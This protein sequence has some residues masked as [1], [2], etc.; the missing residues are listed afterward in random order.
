[1]DHDLKQW[2]Q[3]YKVAKAD[4]ALLERII[5]QA[6]NQPSEAAIAHSWWRANTALAAGLV[7][8]AVLGFAGGAMTT[9]DM[10]E[11]RY[12]QESTIDH[13]DMYQMILTPQSFEEVLL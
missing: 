2:L 6:E 1:M 10:S 4:D 5:S 8:A 11:I 12:A 7:V 9:P 3:S 13:N